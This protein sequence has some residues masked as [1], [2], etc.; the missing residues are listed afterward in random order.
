[1]F[2]FFFKLTAET[3]SELIV[4]MHVRN[5]TFLLVRLLTSDADI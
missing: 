3:L 2:L 4:T 1:L 5:E